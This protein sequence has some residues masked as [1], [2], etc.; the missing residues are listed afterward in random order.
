MLAIY[1]YEGNKRAQSGC[2]LTVESRVRGCSLSREPFGGCSLFLGTTSNGQEKFEFWGQLVFS[3]EAVGEVNSTDSAV[4]VNLDS[5]GF[6][7]VSSVGTTSEI[8]QIELN[9]VPAFVE[10]HGHGTNERLDTGGGLIVR[11]AESSADVLIIE[12]LDF[13]GEVFFELTDTGG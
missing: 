4:S 13:E 7:V 3:V 10:S 8:G 2:T 9:L 11:G 12:H 1:E 5:E 6:D